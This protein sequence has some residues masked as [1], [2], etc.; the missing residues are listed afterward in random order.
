[1]KRLNL[2]LSQLKHL[3]IFTTLE[4]IGKQAASLTMSMTCIY[5]T[6]NYSDKYQL[7]IITIQFRTLSFK[8]FGCK[9]SN[10]IFEE[11]DIH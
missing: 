7:K 9:D 10:Y 6:N 3:T 1:M 11:C 8:G 4:K 5:M 2:I